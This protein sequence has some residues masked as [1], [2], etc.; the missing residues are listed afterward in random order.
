M[1]TRSGRRV[2]D[3]I[4]GDSEA[5][6]GANYRSDAEIADLDRHIDA[7][8]A[9]VGETNPAVRRGDVAPPQNGLMPCGSWNETG[10]RHYLVTDG[11]CFQGRVYDRWFAPS[12]PLSSRYIEKFGEFL[13][14]AMRSAERIA[15]RRGWTI[16][17]RDMR[18]RR[19]PDHIPSWVWPV[20]AEVDTW[21]VV[22]AGPVLQYGYGVTWP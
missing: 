8:F 4:R 11:E 1:N 21:I 17:H 9:R 18:F 3:P 7:A 6:Y 13:P 16:D 14:Y 20:R 22:G 12:H 10:W 2:S 15:S 5:E 19:W